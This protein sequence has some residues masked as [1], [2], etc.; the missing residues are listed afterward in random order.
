MKLFTYC[1]ECEKEILVKSNAK[2]RSDLKQELGETILL[3]CSNCGKDTSRHVNDI[4]ATV[5]TKPIVVGVV[6]GIILTGLL[7]SIIGGVSIICMGVAIIIWR[8]QENAVTHFDPSASTQNEQ[9]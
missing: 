2:T 4:E 7:G 9:N 1:Q 6:L 5:S 8:K 3:T